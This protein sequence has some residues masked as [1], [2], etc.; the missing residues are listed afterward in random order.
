MGLQYLP[1]IYKLQNVISIFLKFT[2]F[3]FFLEI[4]QKA[5]KNPV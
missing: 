1:G 5:P 3:Q 2:F 4:A